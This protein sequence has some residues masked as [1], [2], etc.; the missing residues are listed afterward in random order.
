MGKLLIICVLLLG[1]CNVAK[2]SD[3]YFVKDPKWDQLTFKYKKNQLAYLKQLLRNEEEV[4][5]D[6]LSKLS[7]EV[8]TFLKDAKL[9][10]LDITIFPAYLANAQ[11]DFAWLSYLLTGKISGDLGPVTL[12]MLQ[13]F[14]PDAELPSLKGKS[15]DVYSSSLA[16]IIVKQA[17]LRLKD[18]KENIYDYPIKKG[19]KLWRHSSPGYEGRNLGSLKPWYLDDSDEH[20]AQKP[21]KDDPF[22]E[23]QVD[24]IEEEQKNMTQKKVQIALDWAVSTNDRWSRI[25]TNYLQQ[26]DIPLMAQLYIRALFFSAIADANAACYHSK[27]TYLVQRPSQFSHSVKLL[28]TLPNHPSYPS[29]HSTISWTAA[30]LLTKIFPE[31]R[32]KW[33]AIATESGISR[34]WAGIHYPT[35]DANGKNLGIKIAEKALKKS[36]P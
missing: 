35:D 18:E 27:Y 36:Y 22:W 21:P 29:A 17:A 16:S 32:K 34:I 4:T 1:A 11:K 28:I 33:E 31:D 10:E 7:K 25:L 14:A 8:N 26:K 9:E 6:D 19:E 30:T 13:L 2:T 23:D 15:F 12:W 5:V 3:A 20:T 24:Q